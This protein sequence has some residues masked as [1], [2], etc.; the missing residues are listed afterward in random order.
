MQAIDSTIAQSPPLGA[1]CSVTVA[2]RSITA[3]PQACRSTR[4]RS[5]LGDRVGDA[6][7]LG[8]AETKKKRGARAGAA[9]TG[10]GGAT[11]GE[12][13]RRE[14][15]LLAERRRSERE[16]ERRVGLR[17]G[18]GAGERELGR[19]MGAGGNSTI[20]STSQGGGSASLHVAMSTRRSCAKRTMKCTR[21]DP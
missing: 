3:S 16:Q 14:E 10:G 15:D 6:V 12:R 20:H 2:L 17:R 18:I 7:E 1:K 21:M 11:D 5:G 8:G 13:R 4:R 9:E 19:T